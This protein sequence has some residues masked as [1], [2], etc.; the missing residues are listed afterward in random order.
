[1]KI[2]VFQ[3]D[4]FQKCERMFYYEFINRKSYDSCW[5]KPLYMMFSQA[6][7]N[8]LEDFHFDGMQMKTQAMKDVCEL[9]GIH[10]GFDQVRVMIA[11]R[12]YF[13]QWSKSNVISRFSRVK[14]EYSDEYVTGIIKEGNNYF[15]L[16][17]RFSSQIDKNIAVEMCCDAKVC[18]FCSQIEQV[19][20]DFSLPDGSIVGIKLRIVKKNSQVAAG[21]RN[22]GETPMNFLKRANNTPAVEINLLRNQVDVYSFENEISLVSCDIEMKG[23]NKENFS[24]NEESCIWN[25]TTDLKCPYYHQCHNDFNDENELF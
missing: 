8:C 18:L 12:S 21:E 17:N 15:I 13:A 5:K 11:L 1:M 10:D 4:K 22:K 19:E 3:K 6:A 25:K 24:K 23:G 7:I 2:S 14:G 9:H 16:M 20:K